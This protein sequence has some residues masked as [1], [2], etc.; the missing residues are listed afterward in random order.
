MLVAGG[1]LQQKAE[2]S[3]EVTIEQRTEDGAS[4]PQNRADQ[5][6]GSS[7]LRNEQTEFGGELFA[8]FGVKVVRG[9]G[10][11]TSGVSGLPRFGRVTGVVG[12]LDRV[13][14]SQFFGAPLSSR[15]RGTST[16]S[17]ST[18]ATCSTLT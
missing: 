3:G 6:I 10:V 13:R 1:G 14:R 16:T 18:S 2:S 12:L 11:A 7:V 4:V 17:T 8:L 9:F 5:K 15:S